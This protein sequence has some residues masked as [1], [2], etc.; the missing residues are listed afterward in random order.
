MLC[1]LQALPFFLVLQVQK[2][3]KE[4]LSQP[5]LV[6]VKTVRFVVWESLTHFLGE[7]K[8][9]LE[10]YISALPGPDQANVAT[11]AKQEEVSSFSGYPLQHVTLFWKRQKE[12][13]GWTDE[14]QPYLTRPISEGCS[15][16]EGYRE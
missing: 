12:A 4:W 9:S 16:S 14:K 1:I 5:C 15:L 8:D 6:L 3:V 10:S 7:G 11:Y 13:L 2:R